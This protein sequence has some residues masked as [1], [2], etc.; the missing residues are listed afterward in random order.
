MKR[1]PSDL[2]SHPQKRGCSRE[3][4][5]PQTRSLVFLLHSR[6]QTLRFFQKIQGQNN[7]VTVLCQDLN[8]LVSLST[9]PSIHSNAKGYALKHQRQDPGMISNSNSQL[10]LMCWS[11]QHVN[12]LQTTWTTCQVHQS[13][14]IFL[15]NILG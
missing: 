10:L 9:E 12:F 1:S 14:Q 7:I 15:P 2:S 3:G 6:Y 13:S 8:K 5:G 4:E 11:G